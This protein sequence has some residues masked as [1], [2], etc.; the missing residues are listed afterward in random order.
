VAFSNDLAV[1]YA[2]AEAMQQRKAVADAELACA[3]DDLRAA[4]A[5]VKAGREA[6]LQ[7]AQARA[8]VAAPRKHRCR[9]PLPMPPK[10]WSACQL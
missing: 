4:E 9:Q 2:T 8:S 3:Q 5:L 1:T 6:E 10:R 7:V